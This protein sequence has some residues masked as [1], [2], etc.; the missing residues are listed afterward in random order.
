MVSNIV[1]DVFSKGFISVREED[2]LSI[3]LSRFK[4]EMPPVLA[5]VD[6]RGKYKGVLARQ[7]IIRSRLNPNT[8]K[9]KTWRVQLP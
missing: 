9:A 8:T 6:S 1:K 4:G 2:P 7:W 3:C 5:V